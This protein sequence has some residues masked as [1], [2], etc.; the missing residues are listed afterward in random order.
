MGQRSRRLAAIPRE[1]ML[2]AIATIGVA[3]VGVAWTETATASSGT[4]SA[5]FRVTGAVR[6]SASST[7]CEPYSRGR[8]RLVQISDRANPRIEVVVHDLQ[9]GTVNLAR[10]REDLVSFGDS[11]SPSQ[12][13]VWSA[14]WSGAADPVGPSANGKSYGSGTVVVTSKTGS[15][16]HLSAQLPA[17]PTSLSPGNKATGT[18]D[19]TANWKC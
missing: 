7:I 12:I 14:G 11:A 1:M 4:G 19:V 8:V 17:A 10:T 9:T 13:R 2:I 6:V 16:G 3:V 15:S 18:V 5:T